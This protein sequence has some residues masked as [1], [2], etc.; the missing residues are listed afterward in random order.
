MGGFMNYYAHYKFLRSNTENKVYL[1]DSKEGEATNLVLGKYAETKRN[2]EKGVSGKEYLCFTLPRSP[3][4]RKYF[5]YVFETPHGKPLTSVEG[6]NGQLRTF[7][8]GKNIGTRDLI[9]FQ[10]SDDMSTLDM[11]FVK[12]GAGTKS[13]K[14]MNFNLWCNT[15]VLVFKKF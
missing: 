11:Y 15:N 4:M 1:L 9:L 8:D 5:A 7:G 10:F 13:D 6:L 14:I 2:I 3:S 12:D